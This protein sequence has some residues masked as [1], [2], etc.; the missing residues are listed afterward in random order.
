MISL[1]LFNIYAEKVRREALEGV[2][3]GFRI[4]GRIVNNLRYADDV[5]LIATSESD[6]QELVDRVSR[7]SVKAGLKPG[8]HYPS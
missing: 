1:Y 5:V 2:E 7:A 6:L 3:M 4:G 8:F